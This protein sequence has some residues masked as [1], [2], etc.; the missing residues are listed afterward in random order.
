MK[1]IDVTVRVEQPDLLS[2]LAPSVGCP[3]PNKLSSLADRYA[4]DSSWSAHALFD[5]AIPAGILGLELT[6]P[7][8]GRI[9]HIAVIPE[10]RRLGLGRRMIEGIRVAASLQELYAETDGDAVLFYERCGFTVRSLGERHPGVE[11]FGCW[12]AAV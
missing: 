5:R 10:A 12:W 8:C 7:G 1:L 2:I 11:R 6:S 4:R 9:R 3:T